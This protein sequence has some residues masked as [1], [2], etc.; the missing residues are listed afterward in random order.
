MK[1]Y[2]YLLRCADG[3]IYTGWTNAP[4][5]IA[6]LAEREGKCLLDL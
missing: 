5:G 6:L 1:A 3:T 4:I 2:V